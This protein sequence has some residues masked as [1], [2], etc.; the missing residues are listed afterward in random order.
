M[1]EF[2]RN[3]TDQIR[4]VRARDAVAKELSDHI[5]DQAETYEE[6]GTEHEEAVRMAV[7]EMG[8]PVQIGVELDRIHRPQI[9]IR[10]IVMVFVFS[11]GGLMLQ[12][13]GGGYTRLPNVNAA[14]VFVGLFGRQCLILLLAF[15][16]MVGMYFLDYSFIGRYGILIYAAMT[17]LFFIGTQ[18]LT[19]VNG[20]IPVMF[21]L[22]YLYIPA[23]V[24]VLYQLRG[25]GYGAVVQC[26]ILQFITVAF[27][28]AFTNLMSGTC[29]IYLMQTIM[30][31]LA[32]CRNWFAVNRKT[33]IAAVIFGTLILPL[34]LMAGYML[35]N[36]G[37][38]SFRL[39]RIHAW[40]K[41]EEDSRGM[42]YVYMWLREE[43]SQAR[44]IGASRDTLFTADNL[45]D[46][47]FS[48]GPF[49][50]IQ[51]MCNC[52]IL[53]GVIVVLAF[54]A[55]IIHA[56]RI[57]RQQKNQ[58]GFM[59]SA[60]C[61]MVF[62]VNCVEGVLIN[63]GYFPSME[64]QLPFLSYGVGAMVTYAVFIGLLLSIYRN[65][66]IVTDQ[67]VTG[68]SYWRLIVKLEKR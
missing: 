62:L 13:F 38:L 11:L 36:P 33:T 55:L 58:L 32:V 50:L 6:A 57:V 37:F 15:A 65:E 29:V 2:I 42:G 60:A 41:P 52:G 66:K 16:V 20:R 59:L 1:E 48:T 12:Y 68:G 40:L 22:T 5:T 54:A 39:A 17:I 19:T 64:V 61:F 56:F 7:R 51:I 4:C 25:R 47:M 63:S 49:I 14:P 44:W 34:V 8:D 10:M 27:V 9:D 24:G 45:G 53:V 46:P 26:I 31:I 18:V 23:Y 3:I 21:M 43:L 28:H 67:A 35:I 30:L